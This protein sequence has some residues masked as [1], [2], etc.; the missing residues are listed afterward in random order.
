MNLGA[1]DFLPGGRY[2]NEFSL[3]R[4]ARL[5]TFLNSLGENGF[6]SIL[7]RRLV[8]VLLLLRRL[9]L[10]PIFRFALYESR[11][12]PLPSARAIPVIGLVRPG[13]VSPRLAPGNRASSH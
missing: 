9:V 10:I 5:W 4:S 13:R 6:F 2:T 1:V 11:V 7:I 3:V 12:V 8:T